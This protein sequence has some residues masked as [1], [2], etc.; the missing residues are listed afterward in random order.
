MKA[1]LI[2]IHASG[3]V[4]TVFIKEF[5]G[6]TKHPHIAR[7]Y[8]EVS[9][10]NH[11]KPREVHVRVHYFQRYHQKENIATANTM[12]LLSRL[13]QHSP[14]AFYR[15]LRSLIQL[16]YFEPEPAFTIQDVAEESVPDASITQAGFK[17]L[18]ETKRT[19]T[20]SIAQL[21]RHLHA[22]KDEATKVLI[23]LAPTPMNPDQLNTFSN[24][25]GAYNRSTKKGI[26]HVNTTFLDIADA[27]EQSIS[28]H[29][30][31]MQDVL[32]DFRD[33]CAHDDLIPHST[34]SNLMR[35]QLAGV[36]F[37]RNVSNRIY[38]CKES[39]HI[40][41][42]AYLGLYR[43]KSVQ[44]IGRLLG[45]AIYRIDTDEI[46][47]EQGELPADWKTR[48]RKV[49]QD[50]KAEFGHCD[51]DTRLYFVEQ[52]YPTD[53]RKTTA[54]G[55]IGGRVFKL[56]EILGCTNLPKDTAEIAEALAQKTWE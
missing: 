38:Y 26:V 18:I 10:T 31:E 23:T 45:T 50:A 51:V 11:S 19:G 6:Q 27:I 29:D 35:M 39:T 40:R 2:S 34:G 37:E 41:P 30:Y 8:Y 53:F 46:Q 24:I 4:H 43:N 32:E 17:L 1:L 55:C 16:D 44:A 9:E 21:E 13:Y 5:A 12:L 49:I 14:D 7:C 36:T 3:R 33:F 28:E 47:L 48:C 56:D 54:G 25:L 52:F 20:F 42:F 15:T 22:F